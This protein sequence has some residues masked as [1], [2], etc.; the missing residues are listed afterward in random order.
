M[1]G[2]TFHNA[3]LLTREGCHELGRLA[4]GDKCPRV[5][6][7]EGLHDKAPE[8]KDAACAGAPAV[9]DCDFPRPSTSTYPGPPDSNGSVAIDS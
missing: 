5:K 6:C 8:L 3:P 1:F 4:L 7:F 9:P 2:G